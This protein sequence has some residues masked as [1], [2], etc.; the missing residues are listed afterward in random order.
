M[1]TNQREVCGVAP[2]SVGNGLPL[3][4]GCYHVL[5]QC[6]IKLQNDTVTVQC[7]VCVPR[8]QGREE[9]DVTALRT[10]PV[11]YDNVNR[12]K[13][14]EMMDNEIADYLLNTIKCIYRNTKIRIKF[15]DAISEPIQHKQ[16]SKTGMWPLSG[17]G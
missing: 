17:I 1:R 2:L 10:L 3:H 8:I 4:S 13:L 16:S 11:S 7:H 9:K 12:D 15:N 5:V 14:W 6:E